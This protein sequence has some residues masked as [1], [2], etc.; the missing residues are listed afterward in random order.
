MGAGAIHGTDANVWVVLPIGVGVLLGA[1]FAFTAYP[2]YRAL[3][4]R[5][6]RP[7]LVA[8]GIVAATT[9]VLTGA[10]AVLGT[11]LIQR[12]M[13]AVAMVPAAVAPGGAGDQLAHQLEAPL[14]RIGL[15]A[16][17]ITSYLK[18]ATDNAASSLSAGAAQVASA[19]LDGVLALFFMAT[20]MFFV[21]RQW[22]TLEKRAIA[23][24]PLNR[25]HTTRLFR[26]AERLGRVVV[27]GNFGTAVL[28]GVIAA[29]G[30]AI[31][32][33]PEWPLLGALTSVASLVPV[34]GT[35]LVWVPTGLFLLASGRPMAGLLVLTWG[36]LAIV[37][38]CDYVARPRLVGAGNRMSSWTTT[39]SL[40]GGLKLFGFIGIVL[41]PMIV[42]MALAVL[43]VYRRTR[44]FGRGLRV[45]SGGA[46]RDTWDPAETSRRPQESSRR[47][48]GNGA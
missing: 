14:S 21:L 29:I 7:G 4:H 45:T 32:R 1:V 34:V 43:R 15:H 9:L 24:L 38:F 23:L 47:A 5:T 26:E 48:A 6:N 25:G 19:V 42:G 8:L 2:R 28:Q 37:G 41:G 10:M 11:L 13:A 33:V 31:V 46:A 22:R 18:S 30:F 12:G 27:I 20:T 16:D 36:S 40:F 35:L 39:V 44:R 3:A 17:A